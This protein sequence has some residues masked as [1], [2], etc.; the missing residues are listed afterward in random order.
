MRA[1][2]LSDLHF[3]AWT[4][5]GARA[6]EFA[7][8][9]LEPELEDIDELVLLGDVFDFLFSTVELAF[10][11][12]EPFFALLARKLRG[13]RITFLAGNHDHHIALRTLRAAVELKVATGA[14][15]EELEWAFA[16]EYMSF[17]ERFMDRRLAGVDCRMV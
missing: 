17:F 3:G 12:A 5:S 8:G 14:E 10:E 7:L 13:R 6:R 4:G 1:L 11:Q 15:G 16:G 9:R 2:A